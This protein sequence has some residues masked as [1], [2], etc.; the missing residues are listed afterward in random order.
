MSKSIGSPQLSGL[1]VTRYKVVAAIP[2]LNTQESISNIVLKCRKFVDEVIVVDD[3]STDATAESAKSFGARVISHG[4][5]KGYGEAMNSCFEAARANAADILVILDGDG[6]HNPDEIP[7]L[8]T[9]I[10][11]DGA[12]MVIGSRFLSNKNKIPNYRKFGIGLITFLWNFGSRIKVT[13]T[14]SGFR[15]YR[16]S[17]LKGLEFTEDGMALS[18]EILEKIRKLN[19]RIKEVPITCSYDNNNS[20]LCI[21]AF[22]HGFSVAFSVIRI[23]FK[24]TI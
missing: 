9:P 24:N 7:Q 5:N 2:C 8:L 21:K 18:I 4:T 1:P 23:R 3:G 14:Q 13:D 6:Q 11:K 16:M 20:H 12:S 17:L 10:L 22:C 15:A 19:P